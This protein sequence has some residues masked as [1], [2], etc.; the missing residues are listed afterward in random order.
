MTTKAEPKNFKMNYN[1]ERQ[2]QE[3]LSN[4]KEFYEVIKK[5][6]QGDFVLSSS[7]PMNHICSLQNKIEVFIVNEQMMRV[8]TANR[9]QRIRDANFADDW[10]QRVSLDLIDSGVKW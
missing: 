5:I 6:C 10:L 2:E 3:T 1:K 8:G 9:D 7:A 4:H